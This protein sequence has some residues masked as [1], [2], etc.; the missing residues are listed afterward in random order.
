MSD[1]ISVFETHIK[2]TEKKAIVKDLTIKYCSLTQEVC[3]ACN[4]SDDT[5]YITSRVLKKNYDKRTA[6]ENDFILKYGKEVV[7]LPD[8]I[9][10]NKDG[11]RG[12]Y[13]FAKTTQGKLYVSS[14]EKASKIDPFGLYV[15][16]I[17]RVQKVSYLKSYSLIW[18]WKG[19]EPSS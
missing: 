1:V 18:S 11:K 15:A 17:F 3:R 6:E 7:C 9:Y 4:F 8:D 16:S 12:D 5:V 19:G 13:L 10:M 2:G 14:I